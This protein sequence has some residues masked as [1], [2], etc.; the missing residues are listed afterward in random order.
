MLVA[1]VVVGLDSTQSS[2]DGCVVKLPMVVE[3]GVTIKGFKGSDFK[4]VV[5]VSVIPPLCQ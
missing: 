2:P 5:K 3:L 4:R 1:Y